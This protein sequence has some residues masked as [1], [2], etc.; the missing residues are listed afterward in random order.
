MNVAGCG[1]AEISLNLSFDVGAPAAARRFVLAH[2]EPLPPD[3]VDDAALLVSELVTNAVRHGCPAL[4]VR[5]SSGEK[6]LGV[7]V[8]DEG[9][10]VPP[11]EPQR[12]DASLPT[13]RGLMIVDT[14]SSQ[15]GITPTDPPPGK[16]VW[17]ELAA[18]GG[19]DRV[20]RPA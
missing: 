20:A 11:S 2:A 17:F 8:Q 15:W 7:A 16:T 19:S 1:T 5:V 18:P 3:M 10:A 9:P 6:T 4:T 14:V 12:P 13:G